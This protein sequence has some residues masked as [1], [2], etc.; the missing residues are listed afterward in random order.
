MARKVGVAAEGLRYISV[1]KLAE[2]GAWWRELALREQL[3][4]EL[5]LGVRRYTVYGRFYLSGFFFF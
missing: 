2:V 3:D 1:G 5:E 4:T